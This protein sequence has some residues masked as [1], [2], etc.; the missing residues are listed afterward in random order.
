M[1][2]RVLSWIAP[3]ITPDTV[4]TI[5]YVLRLLGHFLGFAALAFFWFRAVFPKLTPASAALVALFATAC[6]AALDEWHQGSIATRTGKIGDVLLDTS[7]AMCALALCIWFYRRAG[8]T[9][10]A[11][12]AAAES[13][14]AAEK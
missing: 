7:G 6:T 9:K 11:N 4:A 1:L 5:N 3:A 8:R 2:A 12:M 14:T 13:A 10:T